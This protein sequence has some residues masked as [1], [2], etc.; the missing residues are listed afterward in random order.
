MRLSG[1]GVV[2]AATHSGY[3]YKRQ[4]NTDFK[5]RYFHP[6]CNICTR[7]PAD[8]LRIRRS[9]RLRREAQGPSFGRSGTRCPTTRPN[10]TKLCSVRR[11]ASRTQC[12]R[13]HRHCSPHSSS[14]CTGRS[15]AYE[16]RGGGGGEKVVMVRCETADDKMGWLKALTAPIKPKGH[17][18]PWECSRGTSLSSRLRR[19]AETLAAAGSMLRRAPAGGGVGA[20]CRL[21]NAPLPSP[22]TNRRRPSRTRRP[23][24]ALR[25]LAAATGNHEYACARFEGAPIAPKNASSRSGF[26]SRG[27]SGTAAHER[28]AHLMPRASRPDLQSRDAARSQEPASWGVVRPRDGCGRRGLRRRVE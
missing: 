23:L 16:T 2:A 24:R 19:R 12:S 1:D 27:R 3:E 22:S 10:A 26:S 8:V 11:D 14:P 7:R 9:R 20:R 25:A 18:K 4:V 17:K 13:A 15:F 5:K 28:G 6:L 21:P